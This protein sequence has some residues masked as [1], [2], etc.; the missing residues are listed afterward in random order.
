VAG[1][2]GSGKTSLIDDLIAYGYQKHPSLTLPSHIINPDKIRQSPEILALKATGQNLDL[3]AQ[4][5]AYQRRQRLIEARQSLAFETVIS[6]PSRLV[7]LQQ[8][9][10]QGYRVL[11][12]MGIAVHDYLELNAIETLVKLVRQEV[13][14]TLLPQ[15]YGANWLTGG[16]LRVTA[17]ARAGQC[18][19]LDRNAGAAR[20]P[21]PG[22][23]PSYLRRLP[24]V[25]AEK[26]R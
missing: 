6:H 8:L 18:K 26:T 20:T 11:R 4:K 22:D 5:L 7:E 24:G 10:D 21:D 15:L 23:H 2:N 1:P 13:G 12:R 16:N 19:S 9:R 3:A 17:A 25:S 14:V